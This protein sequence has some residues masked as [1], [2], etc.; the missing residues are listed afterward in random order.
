MVIADK[1]L[2]L[3]E[4]DEIPEGIVIVKSGVIKELGEIVYSK[5]FPKRKTK[6]RG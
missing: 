6:K 5:V 2:W 3:T 1:M 4:K